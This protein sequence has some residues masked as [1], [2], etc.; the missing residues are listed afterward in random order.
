VRQV[1][2]CR[3]AGKWQNDPLF[4]VFCGQNIENKSVVRSACGRFFVSYSRKILFSKNLSDSSCQASLQNLEPQGLRGKI[5]ITLKLEGAGISGGG[6]RGPLT[7]SDFGA[8]EGKVRCHIGLWKRGVLPCSMRL[9]SRRALAGLMRLAT[10]RDDG[11]GEEE[12][13]APF[14]PLSRPR[15]LAFAVLFAR[16]LSLPS[17]RF[18]AL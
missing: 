2:L 17:L 8:V 16:L 5:F 7:S 4:S 10:S 3:L 18:Q 1:Y 15:G 11:G 13:A 14:W 12:V 9:S 6:I